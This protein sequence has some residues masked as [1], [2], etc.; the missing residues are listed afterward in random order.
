MIKINN[1]ELSIGNKKILSDISLSIEEGQRLA[2]VGLSGSGKSSLLKCI[3][4]IYNHTGG[5][6]S[7]AG[8]VLNKRSL[9]FIRDQIGYVSQ[10]NGLFPHLTV[11]ENLS[12]VYSDD[13]IATKELNKNLTS[14]LELTGLKKEVLQKFPRE[15]S[16]GQNQRVEIIRALIKKPKILLLDEPTSALD[17]LTKRNFQKEVRPILDKLNTTAIIVTHDLNEA[18]YFSKKILILEG[19][20]VIQTGT[21]EQLKNHPT[22]ELV[23]ELTC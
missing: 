3:C 11:F 18:S 5:Q 15:L 8:E 21:L 12:I 17:L 2:I 22:S 1:L 19:G 13:T 16:G 9:N 7:I 23:K 6:I 10:G 14:M 20:R 4:G